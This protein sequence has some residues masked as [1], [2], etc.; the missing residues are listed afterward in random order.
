[1][2][3]V[4]RDFL[5]LT[6]KAIRCDYSRD[7]S[8]KETDWNEVFN[9]AN[10]N[11]IVAILFDVVK[12]QETL[13]EDLKKIWDL[14][15][16]KTYVRQRRH[17][18]AL[19][20]LLKEL[21]D[22]EIDYASFKGVVISQG[23]PNPSYRISADSDILVDVSDR[24]KVSK[25]IEKRGYV[26][27][28]LKTKEKV[29][30]Y[31]NKEIDHVIELHTSVFEDYE[32]GKIDILKEAGIERADHRIN[33]EIEDN[34]I[35]TLNPTD[36]LIYQIFHI[37]KHFIL[38]GAG[39]RFFTDIVLFIEKYG[40][41]IDYEIFWK[42]MDK[43]GYTQFA[44]NFLTVCVN[45]FGM[46]DKVLYR[47]ENKTDPA[48]IEA[49][50]IDFVYRGDEEK[51][52]SKKWMIAD[53]MEQFL[54]GKPHKAEKKSLGDI[55]EFLFPMPGMLDDAYGYAKERHILLPIAWIHRG[56][57][58]IIWLIFD[59]ASDQKKCAIRLENRVDLLGRVGLIDED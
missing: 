46:D 1:M 55:V 58:K 36:H 35:R 53:E 24:P 12:N 15:K 7:D 4:E 3:T 54:V 44:E 37:V 26:L 2:K 45:Y 27:N 5:E 25:L 30:V 59:R 56:F 38:E 20:D 19:V 47:H 16:F 51:L 34:I 31:Y 50:L 43:C 29:F 39:I 22:Q 9:L 13:P 41:E 23:Y 42:W 14:Y 28:P 8:F 48:V 40:E 52:R 49:L 57:K 10:D 32:G 11:S 18:I 17:F 33:C 21:N 6:K